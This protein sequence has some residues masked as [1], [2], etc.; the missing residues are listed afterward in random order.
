MPVEFVVAVAHLDI[1]RFV[2]GAG[3]A[4]IV[5]FARVFGFVDIVDSCF[6]SLASVL[7]A[8]L[9][10]DLVYFFVLVVFLVVVVLVLG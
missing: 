6:V 1:V 5:H 3:S 7:L 10:V 9:E 4:V 2:V 8:E